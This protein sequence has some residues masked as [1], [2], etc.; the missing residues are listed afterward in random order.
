MT[1]ES[2]VRVVI[3]DEVLVCSISTF[4]MFR[5]IR[6]KLKDKGWSPVGNGWE[7]RDKI[8]SGY[9]G[10]SGLEGQPY[11]IVTITDIFCPCHVTLSSDATS[12]HVE[13]LQRLSLFSVAECQ[14][15]KS[16]CFTERAYSPTY[17]KEG[18]L[19]LGGFF[20]LFLKKEKKMSKDASQVPLSGVVWKNGG[21]HNVNRDNDV[22]LQTEVWE[23]HQ[24]SHSFCESYVL[25]RLMI[26]DYQH[27]LAFQFAVD[28][29]NKNPHLLPN[30]T[31][32]YQL[33]NNFHNNKL[34]V[35]SSLIWLSGKSPVIPNYSCDRQFNSV[36][37]IG[38]MSPSLSMSMASIL[39]LYKVPQVRLWPFDLL[40][41]DKVQYP[42]VYQMGRRE[43]TLHLAFIQLLLHYGWTWVGLMISDNKRG[44][45]FFSD[46][47]EEMVKNGI[48]VAF[49]ETIPAYLY[50]ITHEEI[51][52]I[53]RIMRSSSKVIFIYG[54]TDSLHELSTILL[55]YV[56]YGKMLVTTSS[57]DF[58]IDSS[59]TLYSPF[60]GTMIFSHSKM[61]IPGF[62]D[63]V[64]RLNPSMNREDIFLKSFWELLL[65]CRFLEKS[66]VEM[67]YFS[68]PE[69][70][71]LSDFE[72]INF[73]MIMME[74]SF[75]VYSAVYIV[76]HAL[77][78]MLQT[79]AKETPEHV[80][81]ADLSW[82]VTFLF[83][84]CA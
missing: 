37:V 30:I 21:H 74:L 66:H 84:S 49:K 35:E 46:L 3:T 81:T 82:K 45:I 19:I 56:L 43:S 79:E 80:P 55:N 70:I 8:R 24:I 68:C 39:K 76:A 12:G 17:R 42:Y 33:L 48:C 4:V 54:D 31:L 51:K 18:D 32:G 57:W 7:D 23:M 50:Q 28:E 67:K 29:I 36:A 25:S 53:Y 69:D 40:L 78:Q 71:S 52:L 61:E 16:P 11:G 27:F 60:H 20:S 44:E 63:F 72:T 15:V 9:I 10:I 77:H 64:K 65:N 38:G 1:T 14:M 47:N 13:P 26:K 5:E 62:T 59:Y 58:S 34:A 83:N 22:G 6:E 2:V 75:N 41:T 73:D